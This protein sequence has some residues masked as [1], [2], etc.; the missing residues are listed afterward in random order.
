[1]DK[2]SDILK[3]VDRRTGMTVPEG[4]FADFAARMTADLPQQS[5]SFALLEDAP[6]PSTWKRVRPYVYMAA[7]FAGIWCMMKMFSMFGDQK[8]DLSIENY[9]A[10]STALNNESF[11][12]DYVYP[13]INESE[14]LDQMIDSGIDFD[15]IIDWQDID[16]EMYFYQDDYS[17]EN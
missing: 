5:P 12:D 16:P 14:I 8:A 1:M 15:D 7:M 9:P 6:K 17:I 13:N 3:Q 4:Y 11:I 2:N 10:L